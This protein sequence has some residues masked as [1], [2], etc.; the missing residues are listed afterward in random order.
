MHHATAVQ[1][2]A[3]IKLLS[4]RMQIPNSSIEILPVV[5]QGVVC[6]HMLN[7]FFWVQSHINYTVLWIDVYR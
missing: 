1:F 3:F 5:W 2:S 7:L 4:D 6:A